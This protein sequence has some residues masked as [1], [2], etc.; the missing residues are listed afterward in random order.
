MDPQSWADAIVWGSGTI[1]Y[2][3]GTAIVWG[4]SGGLTAETIA[5]K[6]LSGATNAS[7]Q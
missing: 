2:D 5:W 4:S 1:G 3:Y 6:D 7:G